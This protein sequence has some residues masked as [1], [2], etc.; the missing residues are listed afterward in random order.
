MT[1]QGKPSPVATVA[2]AR[3]LV[4]YMWAVLRIHAEPRVAA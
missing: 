2:V 1:E 3:E 4:G